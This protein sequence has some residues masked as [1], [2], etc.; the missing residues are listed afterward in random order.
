VK[1]R[2]NHVRSQ[3][4]AAGVSF[5]AVMVMLAPLRQ[6]PA[7]M[8]TQH[9]SFIPLLAASG[10]AETDAFRRLTT[11]APQHALAAPQVRMPDRSVAAATR[12]PSPVS[13]RLSHDFQAPRLRWHHLDADQRAALDV[14]VTGLE[15]GCA[16]MLHGSPAPNA[17][18]LGRLH[19]LVRGQAA[20][21]PYQV[22]IGGALE[23]H[24][25]ANHDG[26][27]H[28]C[29]LGDFDSA[30]PSERQL[31]MLDEV[32]DYLSMKL[33]PLPLRLH[34]AD[35]TQGCLGQA[36]PTRELTEALSLR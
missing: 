30:A 2:H 31:A 1:R 11:A 25:P 7:G 27:L 17:R 24:A 22:I 5:A 20:G 21:L 33:G 35:G 14:L 36:F 3:W 12:A 34:Q 19:R 15:K 8:R 13:D 29:L 23:T 10:V 6:G 4:I 9:A 32:M 28:V 16:L 26:V 18:E